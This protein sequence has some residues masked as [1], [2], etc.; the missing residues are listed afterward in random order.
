[1]KWHIYKM[2]SVYIGC[3]ECTHGQGS[4]EVLKYQRHVH[5]LLGCCSQV[6]LSVKHTLS[7]E[8]MDAKPGGI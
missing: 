8:E 3:V 2:K 4:G 1:M 5:A 6:R 7:S